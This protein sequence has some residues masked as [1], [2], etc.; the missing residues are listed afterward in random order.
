MRVLV[1]GAGGQVGRELVIAL[2]RRA[3]AMRRDRLEVVATTRAELDLCRRDHV[4]AAVHAVEPDVII[5]PAA[6]TAVDDCE[7]RPELAFATNAMG[8]R[9]LAEAARQVGA[10]L[11]YLSTDYVFDGRAERPY[12]EWDLPNP[13]S[14][15]GRSKLGG[16]RELDPG[17]TIVRT[18]WV[19]GRFGANMAKTVLRLAAKS[20]DPLHFVDDQRG[21]P[22]IVSDLVERVMD[23]ALSRFAGTF[24][25]TNQGATTWYGFARAVLAA[26]GEDPR[27]VEPIDS[28]SLTPPRPAPRTANSV[29]ENAAL[30]ATGLG[31][32]PAWEDSLTALVHALRAQGGG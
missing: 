24:H 12:V 25:V 1:T 4:L 7:R 19:C 3:E 11:C 5:H 16:E 17:W 30:A 8:T 6:F 23:L 14:V 22:T 32:L 20:D 27:R 29:L 28:A 31:L 2:E 18:S 21:S 26:A 10:H 13:L 15:Y 9:F